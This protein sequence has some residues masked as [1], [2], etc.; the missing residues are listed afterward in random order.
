MS[1]TTQPA[2]PMQQQNTQKELETTLKQLGDEYNKQIET[3]SECE[4]TLNTLKDKSY[5]S[6]KTLYRQF[7]SNDPKASTNL[8]Q[9]ENEYEKNEQVITDKQGEHY[10]ELQSCFRTLQKLRQ[11][12]HTYLVGVINGLQ[13]QVDE[14]KASAGKSSDTP[15][16]GRENNLD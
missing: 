2:Q 1:Q 12:Q 7:K 4:V 16:T 6:L 8:P 11:V 15:Q 5:Q 9:L 14:L 3:L 13:R 10:T